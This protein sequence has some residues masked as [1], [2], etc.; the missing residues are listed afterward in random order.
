MSDFCQRYD[1]KKSRKKHTCATCDDVIPV[2]SPYVCYKGVA[3]G[4]FFSVAICQPCEDHIDECADCTA[5]ARECMNE[6]IGEHRRMAE[7]EAIR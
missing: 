4:Y 6:S 1:V 2:G 5:Q 7:R 3:D